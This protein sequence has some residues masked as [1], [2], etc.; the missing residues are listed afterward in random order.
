[1]RNDDDTDHLR[2]GGIHKSRVVTT[3]AVIALSAEHRTF[4]AE[5]KGGVMATRAAQVT[6]MSLLLAGLMITG[7]AKRPPT[8][9]ASGAP[10]G[11]PPP[12]AAPPPPPNS[13][14][15]PPPRAPAP[16]PAR[17]P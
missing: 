14:A 11:P 9:A 3:P 8:A 10:P 7:C 15:P 1:R 12:P 5:A 4:R 17:P 16:P 6:M 2:R 13:P